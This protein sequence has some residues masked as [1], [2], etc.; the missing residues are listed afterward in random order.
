MSTSQIAIYIKYI[1][2]IWNNQSTIP[3]RHTLLTNMENKKYL[4]YP[5]FGYRT[6]SDNVNYIGYYQTLSDTEE[7]YRR[8]KE[9]IS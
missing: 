6:L 8:L 9:T 7:C 4:P 3:H 1:A 2:P 5:L